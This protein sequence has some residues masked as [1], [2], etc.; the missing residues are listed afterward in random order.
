MFAT[1]V[2]VE[3]GAARSQTPVFVEL[4]IDNLAL[5]WEAHPVVETGTWRGI[6][7]HVQF[8]NVASRIP[9]PL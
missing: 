2:P 8:A 3:R 7:A 5:A 1:P 9:G 4:W 6:V